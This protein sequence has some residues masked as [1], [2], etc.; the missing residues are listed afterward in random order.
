MTSTPFSKI[1]D[2]TGVARNLACSIDELLRVANAGDQRQFYEVLRI[3]KRGKKRRGEYRTVYKPEQ[4]LGVLQKN[5]GA[6]IA[7]HT[8]FPNFVQGFVLRRSIRTN[9]EIHLGQRLLLHA[10]IKNFFD[11]IHFEQVFEAF[12]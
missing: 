5:I 2:L 12:R 7:E 4:R 9:A 11:V 10:D 8:D 1:R 6:W 3:P